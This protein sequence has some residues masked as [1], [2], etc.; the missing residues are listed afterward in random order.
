MIDRFYVGS[1]SN[2]FDGGGWPPPSPTAHGRI[3]GNSV[4]PRRESAAPLKRVQFE[5]RLNEC[6]LDNVTGVLR[7]SHPVDDRIEQA[8][9]VLHDELSEC[10]GAARQGFVNQ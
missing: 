7:V 3:E 2:A 5:K 10:L 9:L 8:I 4:K 6:L 1:F